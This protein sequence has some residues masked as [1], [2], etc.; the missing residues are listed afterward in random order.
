MSVTMIKTRPRS[1][2]G[3]RPRAGG[4]VLAAGTA[5]AAALVGWV[6]A[7]PIAGVDLAVR[8]GSAATAP[9]H[10]G[11]ASVLVVSL[12]AAMAAWGMLAVLE[13]RTK[14]GRRIWTVLALVLLVF[15]LSG[16]LTGGI[17][18]AA[19]VALAL[20]HLTVAA[21]LIP[22]LLRTRPTR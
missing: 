13:R 18:V 9:Q 22:M 8:I 16:P 11:L 21:V 15:S 10:I 12:L 5:A 19:K 2:T 14:H 4:R 1:A 20:L 3:G 7:G 17:T 6:V